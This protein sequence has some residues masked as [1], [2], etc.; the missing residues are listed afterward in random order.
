MAL[1]LVAGC[2]VPTFAPDAGTDADRDAP[3][4]WERCE[5]CEIACH[6]TRATIEVVAREVGADCDGCIASCSAPPV[7]M[8]PSPVCLN[9]RPPFGG[10]PAIYVPSCD[11]VN[12][13]SDPAL[14]RCYRDLLAP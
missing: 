10:G 7:D 14:R 5:G 2:S 1:A 9:R 6:E 13:L 12:D 8:S 4:R 3:I 11:G